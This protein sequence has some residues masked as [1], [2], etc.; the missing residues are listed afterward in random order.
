MG[1]SEQREIAK[2]RMDH[3]DHSAL[4]LAFQ[5]T[6]YFWVFPLLTAMKLSAKMGR[7]ALCGGSALDSVWI[8]LRSWRLLELNTWSWVDGI[9]LRRGRRSAWGGS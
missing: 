4:Q 2:D 1:I 9:R 8:S 6:I 7:F 5:E 3:G